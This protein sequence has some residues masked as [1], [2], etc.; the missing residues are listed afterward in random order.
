MEL[1]N[2]QS[3]RGQDNLS[4]PEAQRQLRKNREELRA[5]MASGYVPYLKSETIARLQTL[6]A[7]E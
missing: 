3:S 4:A 6:V 7:R 2:N 1:Q 5:F